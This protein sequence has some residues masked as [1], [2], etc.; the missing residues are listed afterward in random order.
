MSAVYFAGVER[1]YRATGVDPG[2]AKKNLIEIQNRV[3]AHST[4]IYSNMI[5]LLL[6]NTRSER[7]ARGVVGYTTVARG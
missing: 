6:Y 7:P 5:L 1:L 2:G 3:H 4:T